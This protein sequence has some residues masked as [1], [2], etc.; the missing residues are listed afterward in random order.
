MLFYAYVSVCCLIINFMLAIQHDI[1]F[2]RLIMLSQFLFPISFASMKH[3]C[4]TLWEVYFNLCHP[5]HPWLLPFSDF[6]F[7]PLISTKV[8]QSLQLASRPPTSA[9]HPRILLTH[10]HWSPLASAFSCLGGLF[11]CSYEWGMQTPQS[12]FIYL[13]TRLAKVEK[14]NWT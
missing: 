3:K 8:I 7:F 14:P 10:I 4:L 9:A 2:M 11:I 1:Y 12:Q 13:F 6:S 5:S